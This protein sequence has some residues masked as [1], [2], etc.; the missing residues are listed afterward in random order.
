MYRDHSQVFF[1]SVLVPVQIDLGYVFL[2]SELVTITGHH[3]LVRVCERSE[4]INHC[5][6]MLDFTH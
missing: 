1:P 6:D 4:R 5:C 3:D 2:S